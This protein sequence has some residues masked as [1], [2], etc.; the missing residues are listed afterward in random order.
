MHGSTRA[1]KT[2]AKALG[3]AADIFD[4]ICHGPPTFGAE[5][6]VAACHVACRHTVCCLPHTYVCIY[7]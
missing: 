2:Y 6:M 1:D 5:G 4:S 3:I 7:V